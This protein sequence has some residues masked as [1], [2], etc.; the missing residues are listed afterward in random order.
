MMSRVVIIPFNVA[1]PVEE[2]NR[3][4]TAELIAEE[5]EGILAWLVQGAVLWAQEWLGPNPFDTKDVAIVISLNKFVET[6]CVRGKGLKVTSTRLLDVFNLYK[7]DMGDDA[8]DLK[9][10]EFGQMLTDAG[11]PSKRERDGVYRLNLDL[12]EYGK[13][14]LNVDTELTSEPDSSISMNDVNDVNDV[15]DESGKDDE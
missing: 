11:I 6:C 15:N 13:R 5:S 1:I 14:L 4:L 8:P 2:Q 10:K 7:T 12:N 3:N 9:I